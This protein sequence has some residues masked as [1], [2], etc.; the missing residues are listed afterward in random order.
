MVDAAVDHVEIDG[1]VATALAT[2]DGIK[3]QA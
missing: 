1:A 3:A 2:F